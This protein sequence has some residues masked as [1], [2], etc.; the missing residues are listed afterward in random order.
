MSKQKIGKFVNSKLKDLGFQTGKIQYKQ[1]VR[2]RVPI[3]H[4]YQDKTLKKLRIQRSQATELKTKAIPIRKTKQQEVEDI[5]RRR[6]PE[7]IELFQL[8]KD[9]LV[10]LAKKAGIISPSTLTKL[11]LI[12]AIQKSKITKEDIKEAVE[13][14]LEQKKLEAKVLEEYVDNAS[15]LSKK[16]LAEL[17][18][19]RNT[20]IEE[21]KKDRSLPDLKMPQGRPT[22][23]KIL[24]VIFRFQDAKFR[25]LEEEREAQEQFERKQEEQGRERVMRR[26][27]QLETKKR[28]QLEQK[29]SKTE[30]IAKETLKNIEP[31][32]QREVELREKARKFKL[33]QDL[34]K[35]RKGVD[36]QKWKQVIKMVSDSERK[37]NEAYNEQFDKAISLFSND[38]EQIEM[39]EKEDRKRIKDERVKKAVDFAN[40]KAKERAFELFKKNVKEQIDEKELESKADI[41]RTKKAVEKLSSQIQL[42]KDIKTTDKFLSKL[43]YQEGKAIIKVAKDSLKSGQLKQDHFLPSVVLMAS[44]KAKLDKEVAKKEKE[45][46]R[47]EQEEEAE[48]EYAEAEEK[49]KQSFISE[50]KM[51]ETDF[52]SKNLNKRTP[53]I[54]LEQE[55]LGEL[56]VRLRK[57]DTAIQKRLERDEPVSRSQQIRSQL[58]QLQR[59]PTPAPVQRPPVQR[60][61]PI[62]RPPPKPIGETVIQGRTYPL[63]ESTPV[64]PNT[65]SPQVRP[66]T[67]KKFN[68]PAPQSGI[69][70]QPIRDE[71]EI[72]QAEPEANLQAQAS[73]EDPDVPA[74]A[75]NAIQASTPLPRSNPQEP[76][77]KRK[78]KKQTQQSVVDE[79]ELSGTGHT[80]DNLPE[81]KGISNHDID[82]FLSKFG[83]EYLGCIACDEIPSHIYPKIRPRTRGFFVMNTEPSYKGG[84]HWVCVFMDARPHG[85]SSIEYFDSFADPIPP[86]LQQDIKGI[87]ERL[88]AKTYL[89]L[90]EN[91]IKFQC[92]S[93]DNCGHFCMEFICDRMRGKPF[94]EASKFNDSVRGEDEVNRWKTMNG[95]GFLPS[96]GRIISSIPRPSVPSV[97][98]DAWSG[99]KQR[100]E[101]VRQNFFPAKKLPAPVQVLFDKYK[102]NKVISA[103]IRREPIFA[104]IDKVINLISGGKFDEAKKEQGYD[105]MFHLSLIL[106]LDNGVRLLTEKNERINMITSWKD[107]DKIE[108]LNVGSILNQPTLEQ[109]FNNTEKAIGDHRFFTY[110]AFDQNCQRFIADLLQSNN[111]LS[112]NSKNFILQDAQSIVKKMPFFVS[113]ISQFATDT[114]GRVKQFFG[115]GSRIKRKQRFEN[116]MKKIK[117]VV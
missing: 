6:E 63:F 51:K 65:V 69:S 56:Q 31:E 18:E 52:F 17:Q 58:Q 104:I 67:I 40:K 103:Q 77:K 110:N 117:N 108:Y 11:Q 91:R 15:L 22:K 116:F 87:A 115:F 28:E 24:Q 16:S 12:Q 5:Q 42:S 95:F 112:D 59:Q 71:P 23:E 83:N 55:N 113:K 80:K 111:S 50:I 29:E 62:Q 66:N 9:S 96:F 4:P 14:K 88:D 89:K 61:P 53:D 100:V 33:Q 8:T 97:I 85:S 35:L 73:L 76:K 38:M 68:E 57:L 47:K 84:L 21:R 105:K 82:N 13:N 109:F 30:Q 94:P 107:T 92:E 102:N 70:N 81:G 43:P 46:V 3:Q 98:K 78:S 20:Y 25:K 79:P 93:S 2:K 26:Q 99:V 34:K 44:A 37:E 7:S 86:R 90:K 27:E 41:F 64:E 60:P 32:L 10:D 48:R 1:R 39:K 75:Q 106:T 114:A 36:T 54:V 74:E 45:R 101:Q 72:E 49:E 19:L